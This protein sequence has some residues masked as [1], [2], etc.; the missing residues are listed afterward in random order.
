MV[1]VG[2]FFFFDT[3]HLFGVFTFDTLIF[4]PM[5]KLLACCLIKHQLLFVYNWLTVNFLIDVS[6][7]SVNS[8]LP[9]KTRYYVK[10]CFD[11]FHSIHSI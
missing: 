4:Q 1:H 2:C 9:V 6:S 10:W 7:T 11:P 5:H 3:L 8:A